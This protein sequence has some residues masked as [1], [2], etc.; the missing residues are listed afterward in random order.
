[1]D[2]TAA[3][4]STADSAPSKVGRAALWALGVIF[5]A[6][7]LNYTDRQLV[8]ALED[9]ICNALNLDTEEFG[10]LWSLFTI[11][12]M[13]CAVPIGLLADRFSR[14]RL[15]SFCVV[16]WS[17]ATLASGGAESKS[18]LYV[19]RVFIG[20]GEAGCLVIGPSLI[21]DIFAKRVRGRALSAFYLGMPLGGTAAYILAGVFLKQYGWRN[22]FYLAGAPGFLIAL[23]I[24]LLPDPPRGVTE[25]AEHGLPAGGVRQYLQLLKTK[26]LLLIILAQ[27][28]AV[29]ILVPLIHFGVKFFEDARGMGVEE[30]RIS[31]GVIAL[32]AGSLGNLLSGVIGDRLSRRF[33]GAYALMAGVSFL[34]SWPCLLLG[35]YAESRWVFLPAIMFGSMFIFLCMPAVN[36]QIANVTSP[37]QRAT[38]WA[39]AVFVLH[40]LGD[41]AAPWLFGRINKFLPRQDVF[42]LF[43]SALI[44]AG[45]CCLLAA[46]TAKRDTERV[47][48]KIERRANV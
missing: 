10:S 8:S 46:Y 9:P 15:F 1:M 23:F 34:L 5:A 39:L 4:Q 43:S 36:T 7:F 17:V 13:L 31:L 16:V 45:L 47:A 27:A 41:T 19:A 30:A 44:L 12:Y 28:F 40:L 3:Q 37:A 26:T 21:S 18:I 33:S 11:G 29:F 25:G 14:T 22:L 32:V 48:R 20:V 38:A 2:L 35:F 6:N 24:A 42:I